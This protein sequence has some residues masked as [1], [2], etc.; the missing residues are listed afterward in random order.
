MQIFNGVFLK[1]N[2]ATVNMLHRVEPYVTYGFVYDLDSP[3]AKQSL[4]LYWFFLENMPQSIWRMN[5]R[6]QVTLQP[7]VM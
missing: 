7:D 3:T 2:K 1:V 4:N 6:S 5:E